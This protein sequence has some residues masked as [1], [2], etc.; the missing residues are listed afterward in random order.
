MN[1][2]AIAIALFAFASI[3]TL[4]QTDRGS[5]TGTL[6]DSDGA[7]VNAPVQAKD[8]NGKIYTGTSGS[9]GRFTLKDLPAG[10]YEIGVPRLGI[11]TEPFVKKDVRV[12]AGQVVKL[13]IALTRFN[14]GVIGDDAAYQALR[15]KY[16]NVKGPA[17]RT[18]DGKPDL[19]GVW[20]GAADPNPAPPSMLP[21][22]EAE[23]KRRVETQM[24]DSPGAFCLP[25]DVTPSI[26]VLYQ[27]VQ[28]PQAIVL[29][30]EEE[31]HYRQIF[32]D[33]RG[34]PSD[35][36]PSWMGHSVGKWE[37]TSLVVDSTGFNDKTWILWPLNLPH[38]EMLHVTERYR[39]PD[40]GHLTIEIS[41][42]DA[43]TFTKPVERHLT[44]ILAPGEEILETICNE[45]NKYTENV[46]IAK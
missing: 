28:A 10:T 42:D 5:I 16:A 19:S 43:G 11:R 26:P 2:P 12:E 7:V 3:V 22:A 23:W 27:I 17:P 21:W 33:G 44:W 24:R 40:L 32:L 15:N 4:A 9:M 39:R 30:F 46:G 37:G 1:R 18:R 29:L 45:N 34:H 41:V 36:N 13:D 25:H 8:A 14:L 20:S 31:P 38:T 35:P 6:S